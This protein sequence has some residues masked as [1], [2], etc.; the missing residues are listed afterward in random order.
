MS[1]QTLVNGDSLIRANYFNIAIDIFSVKERKKIMTYNFKN[2]G[3]NRIINFGGSGIVEMKENSF[4]IGSLLG[5]IYIT[6]KDSILSKH[7]L[8]DLDIFKDREY[9]LYGINSTKPI[10]IDDDIFFYRVPEYLQQDKGYYSEKLLVKYNLKNKS[11]DELNVLYPKEYHS[12]LWS[13]AHIHP[14]FTKNSENKIIFSF[15]IN[16]HL[17][18]YDIKTDSMVTVDKCV[19]SKFDNFPLKPLKSTSV[20]FYEE[21]KYIKGQIRYLS[22]TYDKYKK[23]YYRMIALPVENDDDLISRDKDFLVSPIVL[24][25]L[26]SDFN[27]LAEKK[28]KGGMFNYKDYFV[29]EEGFWLSKNNPKNPNFDEDKLSF[30]LFNLK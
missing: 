24:M 11:L 6:Y 20:D 18:E 22:I 10:K 23:L 27:V 7:N 8:S 28:L 16:S 5:E 15:P 4:L 29:N 30:S 9:R 12:G 25:V 14:S 19:K 1:T 3:P 2:E 17:Y 26:D 21:N 13:F